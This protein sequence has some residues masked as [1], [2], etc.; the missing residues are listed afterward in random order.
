MG[1]SLG[2]PRLPSHCWDAFSKMAEL[3]HYACVVSPRSAEV[4]LRPVP[5]YDRFVNYIPEA[6]I[7]WATRGGDI[8][9]ADRLSRGQ[10]R[11]RRRSIEKVPAW[12]IERVIHILSPQRLAIDDV[13]KMKCENERGMLSK[14]LSRKP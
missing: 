7:T 4:C 13:K 14:D 9:V 3:V 8:A 1:I 6:V 12:M 10:Q 5:L 2:M 11:Q